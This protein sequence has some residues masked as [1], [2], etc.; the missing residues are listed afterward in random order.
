[1]QSE[2]SCLRETSSVY[3]SNPV[4]FQTFLGEGALSPARAPPPPNQ[5]PSLTGCQCE[6]I[7]LDSEPHVGTASALFIDVPPAINPILHVVG[8]Q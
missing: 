6:V 3:F 2:P 4:S 7:W 8:G 1:M 5:V